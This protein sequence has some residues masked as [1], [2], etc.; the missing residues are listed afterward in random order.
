M[1]VMKE[2]YESAKQFKVQIDYVMADVLLTPS[3]TQGPMQLR[4]QISDERVN[5]A[6]ERKTTISIEN[7]E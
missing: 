6:S 7:I 4:H 3:A 1:A 5:N 2:D